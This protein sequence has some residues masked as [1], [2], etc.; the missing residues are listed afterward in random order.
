MEDRTPYIYFL[1]WE[2]S[3][4]GPPIWYIG[5]QHGK[6]C[7]PDNLWKTY[8]TSS[9]YV[10]RQRKV[11]GEPS[12][13]YTIECTDYEGQAGVMEELFL[14][15]VNAEGNTHFLNASNVG[16]ST[17]KYCYS[18]IEYVFGLLGTI[19]ETAF[20]LDISV[21]QVATK[22]YNNNVDYWKYKPKPTGRTVVNWCKGITKPRGST[23]QLRMELM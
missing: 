23:K 13:I 22:L 6:G 8:F 4:A 17:P 12:K 10:E 20:A 18:Q 3:Y 5:S 11:F 9:E 21:Q 15:K 19:H 14:T 1:M 16:R 2:S 7:H